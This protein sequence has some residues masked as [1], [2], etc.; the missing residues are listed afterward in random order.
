MIIEPFTNFYWHVVLV[1]LHILR[2]RPF[3]TYT[4]K[5]WF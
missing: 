3:M 2:G 5:S 4:R 1:E